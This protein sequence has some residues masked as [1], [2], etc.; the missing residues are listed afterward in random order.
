MMARLSFS[1]LAALALAAGIATAI[2]R[3]A[4]S[5]RL[6][7]MPGR[8]GVVGR[9]SFERYGERKV[10]DHRAVELRIG[11]LV[12]SA[13][14]RS[15][16]LPLPNQPIP[17]VHAAARVSASRARR[18][19][20]FTSSQMLANRVGPAN[21]CRMVPVPT[22][23]EAHVSDEAIRRARVALREHASCFWSR[24]PDAPLATVADLRLVVRRLRQNGRAA[25]WRAAR[26]I[27]ACL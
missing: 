24:S 20:R 15:T 10:G 19:E 6:Y 11:S 23:V 26:D 2:Y 13:T 16:D 12:D 8:L 21:V 17:E 27:E 25:A 7:F 18:A 9:A 4:T 14:D 22:S 3:R 1:L 5:H